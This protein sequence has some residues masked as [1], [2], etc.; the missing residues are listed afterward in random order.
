MMN[1]E[2]LRPIW[3]CTAFSLSPDLGLPEPA[4]REKGNQTRFFCAPTQVTGAAEKH[5]E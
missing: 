1:R 4:K 2:A 3:A 5:S